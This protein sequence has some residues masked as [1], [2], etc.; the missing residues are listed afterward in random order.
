V[1]L[2]F[3]GPNFFSYTILLGVFVLYSFLSSCIDSKQPTTVIK[4]IHV[5]RT[6]TLYVQDYDRVDIYQDSIITYMADKD[7][8]LYNYYYRVYKIIE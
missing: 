5:D 8:E 1:T 2:K 7:S 3:T 6:D 4:Y